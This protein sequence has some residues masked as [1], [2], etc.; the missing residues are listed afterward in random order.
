MTKFLP[1]I[2]VVIPTIA[3]R[4]EKGVTMK[5]VRSV[6]SAIE[7]LKLLGVPGWF[8][9]QEDHNRQGAAVTRHMG[10]SQVATE[11]VA[12]LDDDDLMDGEHLNELLRNAI[13]HN[14]DYVWSRFRIGLPDGSTRPGPEPLGRGT[15]E[16][17][18]DE[19]PAQT[20][21]TTLVRTEL[22]L[23]VGGFLQQ[24][25]EGADRIADTIDGQRAGEDWLFTLACRRAGAVFR[26][27]PQVT[28]TWNHHGA[29][30]SGLPDRW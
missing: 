21:V 5:A 7:W 10:L 27:V 19:Q 25:N 11:W 15:F 18:N 1:G 30:T 9:V 23:D 17:W 14:A 13:F 20:T 16:Q 12:F 29:N 4:V 2:T 3:P 24:R 28:W 22:A 6:L 8:R 26:H